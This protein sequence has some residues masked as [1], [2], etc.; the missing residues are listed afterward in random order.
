VEPVRTPSRRRGLGGNV[1]PPLPTTIESSM[2]LFNCVVLV[3]E[4]KNSK[5]RKMKNKL[6]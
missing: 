1:D 4:S 3:P 2:E 6:T 5:M